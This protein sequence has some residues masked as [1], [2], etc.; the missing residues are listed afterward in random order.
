VKEN[1]VLSLREL[2]NKLNQ[3]QT[4]YGEKMERLYDIF[5]GIKQFPSNVSNSND[6][7]GLWPDTGVNVYAILPEYTLA[8]KFCTTGVLFNIGQGRSKYQFML[9]QSDEL[10]PRK[11]GKLY[12]RYAKVGDNDWSKWIRFLYQYELTGGKDKDGNPILDDFGL[13]TTDT[14]DMSPE[15]NSHNFDDLG[16]KWLSIFVDAAK[17]ANRLA[18][19]RKIEL[20]GLVQGSAM[21]DGSKDIQINTSAGQ[22]YVPLN[23]NLTAGYR[24]NDEYHLLATLPAS[25]GTTYDYVIVTGHI[26]GYENTQ[27]KCWFTACIS[28]RSGEMANGFYVGSLGTNN[29]VVYKT[30]LNE[31]KVYLLLRGWNDDCKISVYGSN[32]VEIK[33]EVQSLT[34]TNKVWNLQ[35]CPHVFENNVYGTFRGNADTATMAD[36]VKQ[37]PMNNRASYSGDLYAVGAKN[38][39]GNQVLLTEKS[40]KFKS[41]GY[42][43]AKGFSGALSGTADKSKVAENAN[44]VKVKMNATTKCFLLGASAAVGS[45][46]NGVDTMPFYDTNVYLTTTSGELYS[47]L[48]KNYKMESDNADIKDLHVVNKFQIGKKADGVTDAEMYCLSDKQYFQTIRMGNGTNVNASVSAKLY[49]EKAQ[50]IFGTSDKPRVIFNSPTNAAGGYV[51]VYPDSKYPSQ[52]CLEIQG[53]LS[54]TRVYHAVYND[55]AELFPCKIEAEV[56]DVLMLD[57]NS[58]EELYIKSSEGAKCV[59]GVISDTYGCLLGGDKNMSPEELNKNYKPIGLAGR[60]KVNVVGKIEKGDKLVA[61]DNG[62]ARAYNSEK[63]SLDDVIGYAIIADDKTEKRQLKMKIK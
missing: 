54:P 28:N 52:G 34:A 53:C 14:E 58:D 45:N 41:N 55:I 17:E 11:N 47:R 5:G 20:T 19:A 30:S 35:D 6:S 13:P 56:G 3:Q 15:N 63:D 37:I 12:Y 60:V 1:D 32:Q 46:Y 43:E 26:G 23:V 48:F 24:S 38:E 21:F 42:I 44:N 18:D 22:F 57:P 50:L 25:S 39:S 33:H 40:I 16:K 8:V 27:G 59:A 9:V 31:L 2:F 62:C 51:G 61:T 29:L 36:N 4:V 49:M 10:N 7:P